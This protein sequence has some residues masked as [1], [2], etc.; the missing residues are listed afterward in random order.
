[1]PSF[2]KISCGELDSFDLKCFAIE[3]YKVFGIMY[4]FTLYKF[5]IVV[6]HHL[7]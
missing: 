1:M 2:G 5:T 3:A 7:R 4:G 6:L